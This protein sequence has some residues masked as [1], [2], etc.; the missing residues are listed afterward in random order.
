MGLA[1]GTI[2]G[3]RLQG[4]AWVDSLRHGRTARARMKPSSTSRRNPGMNCSTQQTR[5]VMATVG[6]LVQLLGRTE[7]RMSLLAA[8][9][10]QIE[11]SG[12]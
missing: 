2:L 10:G 11:D 5:T 3:F 1:K 7:S 9:A 4:F 12:S 6:T 8:T